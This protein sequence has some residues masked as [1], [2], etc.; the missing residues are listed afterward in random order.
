MRLSFESL[1]RAGVLLACCAAL[2]LGTSTLS[3][4]Q[5]RHERREARREW[6]QERREARREWR[7]ERR[8][9]RRTTSNQASWW[10]NRQRGNAYGRYRTR[11]DNGRHLGWRNNRRVDRRYVPINRRFRR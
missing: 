5:N 7:Q 10:R 4:G 2:L 6:R 8:E 3:Y 11:H 9:T 1:R